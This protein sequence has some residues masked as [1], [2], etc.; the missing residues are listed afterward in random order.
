MSVGF[1]V[2]LVRTAKPPGGPEYLAKRL[3]MGLSSMRQFTMLCRLVAVGR[4]P[5]EPA[6][7]AE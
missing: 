3:V 5:D 4:P 2:Q 7:I 6:Q 1:L